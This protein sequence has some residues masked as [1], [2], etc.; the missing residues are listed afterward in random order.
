MNAKN[1]QIKLMNAEKKKV[2]PT[3]YLSDSEGKYGVIN[4]RFFECIMDFEIWSAE[5]FADDYLTTFLSKPKLQE[6]D[7]AIGIWTTIVYRVHF[8]D[9]KSRGFAQFEADNRNSD[10][11]T[12]KRTSDKEITKEEFETKLKTHKYKVLQED[13]GYLVALK[14][15]VK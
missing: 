4:R 7:E 9:E 8:H 6:N 2:L 13:G 15:Y 14:M 1:E 11:L 3:L 10:G 5:P 12:V